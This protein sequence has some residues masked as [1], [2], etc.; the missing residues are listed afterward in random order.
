MLNDQ[1]PILKGLRLSLRPAREEDALWR[2]R[3]G[4]DPEIVR[5]FGG[6]VGS[7]MMSSEAAEHWAQTLIADRHNWII[8]LGEQGIGEIRLHHINAQDQTASLAIG[9]FD[10]AQLGRGLGREAISLV[11]QHGF[12][13]LNL[14]RLGVRVLAFNARAIRCYRACGFRVE[15]RE[16]QSCRIGDERHDD[17]IMGL[18][19]GEL[20]QPA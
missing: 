18:L 14:H 7:T 6:T 2:Q 16:R 5:M 12:D 11:A 15:G 13:T 8:D 10:R 19:A 1:A 17:I 9:I 3:L 20:L 4:Y